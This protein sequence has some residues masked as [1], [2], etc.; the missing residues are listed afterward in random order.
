ME[1][2]K[3]WFRARV[4]HDFTDPL[5]QEKKRNAADIASVPRSSHEFPFLRHN[6]RFLAPIILLNN[7]RNVSL[8]RNIDGR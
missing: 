8:R 5:W 2:D 1:R 6:P 3:S 4:K 7:P